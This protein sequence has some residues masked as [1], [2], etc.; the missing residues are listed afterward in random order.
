MLSIQDVQYES[1]VVTD[2]VEDFS[3]NPTHSELRSFEDGAQSVSSGVG[4]D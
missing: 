2:G 1:R 4:P 3:L